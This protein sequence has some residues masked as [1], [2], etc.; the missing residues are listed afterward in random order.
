MNT[1]FK[2]L[3]IS[4]IG[5]LAHA[6]EVIAPLEFQRETDELENV[7]Y[8]YKDINHVLDKFI[9]TWIYNDG[10]EYFEITYT[11]DEHYWD[12]IS[13]IDHLIADFKYSKNGIEIYN[14][15]TNSYD[16][17]PYYSASFFMDSNNTN[18]IRISYDE[19]DVPLGHGRRARLELIYNNDGTQETIEWGRSVAHWNSAPDP[20]KIPSLMVLVKQ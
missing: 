6:Q 8:Y 9:G 3:M 4:V 11:L 12:G 16:D 1:F 7:T 10:T 13:Y 19:P 17:V 18:N 2:F 5:M 14:S 20:F 15:Y